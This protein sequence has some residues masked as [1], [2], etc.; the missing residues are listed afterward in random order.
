MVAQGQ[1]PGVL[2][3]FNTRI[4]HLEEYEKTQNH[5]AQRTEE[6]LDKFIERTD[7]KF[8]SLHVKLDETKEM[9]RELIDKNNEKRDLNIRQRM[10][11]IL[12]AL[13]GIPS[14]LWAFVQ[15]IS[16]LSKK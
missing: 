5:T 4:K 13:I 2:R 10:T 9:I 8:E 6:K 7:N 3:E 11:W 16:F 12:T 14:T 15:L 1:T